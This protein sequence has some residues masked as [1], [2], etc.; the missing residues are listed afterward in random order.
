[1]HDPLDLV[2]D[3]LRA[4]AN[5]DRDR[6]RL[7]AARDE[8]H[9]VL[10][11]LPLLDEVGMAEVLRR[12][13][14]EV[15]D[16]LPA[17]R[18][19]E[20]L[21]V[22]LLRPPDRVDALLGEV[23]LDEVVDPLLADDDVRAHLL[24][25]VDVGLQRGLLLG[26]ER[27]HLVRVVDPD[28]RGELCLLDLEGPVQEHDLRV[29]HELRHPRVDPLLVQDDPVHELGV[30]QGPAVLLHDKDV[31]DVRD[32]LAGDL[33]QDRLHAHQMQGKPVHSF[34]ICSA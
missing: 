3:V 7:L 8:R 13:V 23:V 34:P 9:L 2:D 20:L 15:D 27:L 14:V 29:P 25:R 30:R 26:E 28:L 18:L 22:A 32:R 12:H 5:Q 4:A 11:D 10:A 24:D 16:E 1:M 31:V 17:G 33:F 6:L 21:H 19:R